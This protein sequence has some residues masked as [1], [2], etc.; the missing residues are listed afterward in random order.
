MN[1]SF[2]ILIVEDEIDISEIIKI[3]L[4]TQGYS[5]DTAISAEEAL[6]ISLNYYDLFI[7]DIMLENMTGIELAKIVKSKNELRNIPIIFLTAKSSEQNKLDGFEIGADD[8]ITK[9][10][11]V[12]ELI[13]RVKAVLHRSHTKNSAPKEKITLDESRK[14]AVVNGS[15]VILTKKEY[16]L[17]HTLIQNKKMLFSRDQLLDIVW[18]DDG[19]VTDRAVDV[20]VRRLRKKLGNEGESIKTRSGLGYTFDP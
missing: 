8:Y 10:F 15:D 7:F 9:P 6:K 11:S 17:L 18:E 1:S 3:N 14:I 20:M 4:E 2:K 5:I 19:S 13:A 12:K 16:L